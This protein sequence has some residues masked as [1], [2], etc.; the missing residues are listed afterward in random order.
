MDPHGRIVGFLGMSNTIKKI[1]WQPGLNAGM[2]KSAKARLYY[3][4]YSTSFI[5]IDHLI[6]F[7]C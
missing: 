1:Q 3:F 5:E 6:L 7:L 4:Y 2:L